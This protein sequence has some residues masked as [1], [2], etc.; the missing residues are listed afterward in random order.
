V[1]VTQEIT[2]L[3]NSA[4]RLTFTYKN[5]D[6]HAK[7]YE[8][9][10]GLAKDL[11]IKGFRKGKAPIPVLERKLGNALKEDV[12]NSI[13]GSTVNDAMKSED[14]PKDASPLGYSEPEVEGKP[15][16]DLSGDLVFSVKY[17]VMP[18]ITINKWEGFEVEADTAEVTDADVNRQLDEI[19]EQNAIV[20]DK[21][22]GEPAEKGDVVTLDYCELTEDGGEAPGTKREDFTFNLGSGHNTFKFDDEI[23]G[24]KKDETRDIEKAYPEDFEDKD[25]AGKTIKLRV[26]ITALKRRDIPGDDELAQDV[27]ENFKTIDDLR[28]S[29]RKNLE[30]GLELYIK[31]GKVGKIIEKIIEEN[32]FSVPESMIKIEMASQIQ[33][34]LGRYNITGEQAYNIASRFEN[35][36]ARV[37]AARS[38][39]KIL[40]TDK[41]KKDLNI[42]ASD[43]DKE[44][45]YLDIAN[46]KGKSVDEVKE[47]YIKDMGS[48]AYLA[49]EIEEKK[50]ADILLEKNTVKTGKKVDLLDIFARNV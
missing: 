10:G 19:R 21:E 17:D 44:L 28:A 43:K 40:V 15:E 23:T 16:L 42:E 36:E 39:Q 18:K 29:I 32:P 3:D 13:I 6:L 30:K 1:A 11:Q 48:E 47:E 26:K 2:H 24:M 41:L 4:V 25:L 5:E 33:R 46:A 35:E 20:M 37:V 22:D 8:I 31:N 27:D 38:V 49:E 45:F 50:L 34:K 9:V 14:F 7:Y 12:L